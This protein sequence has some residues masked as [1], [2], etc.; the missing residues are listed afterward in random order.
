MVLKSIIEIRF[1]RQTKEMIKH[2]NSLIS[3]SIKYSLLFDVNIN[4]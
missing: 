2:Y 3:V 4:A 1:L